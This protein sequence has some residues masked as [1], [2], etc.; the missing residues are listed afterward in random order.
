VSEVIGSRQ[1]PHKNLSYRDVLEALFLKVGFG[2]VRWAHLPPELGNYHT[3]QSRWSRWRAS[4]LWD[5]IMDVLIHED[6]VPLPESKPCLPK[7]RMEG[8]IVPGLITGHSFT[9]DLAGSER[10]RVPRPRSS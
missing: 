9:P 6:T 7:M 1:R 8:E 3:I 2:G 4:G 5:E 10:G